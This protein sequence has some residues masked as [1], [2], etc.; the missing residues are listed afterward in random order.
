MIAGYSKNCLPNEALNMFAA[1]LKELKPDRRTMACILP[2]CASLSGLE[3]GKEIHILR[4]GYSS[5]RDVA[6]AFLTCMSSVEF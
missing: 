5:D 3:R 2:P 4:N 1:M 6:N